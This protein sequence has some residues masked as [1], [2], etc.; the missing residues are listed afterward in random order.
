MRNRDTSDT[1]QALTRDVVRLSVADTDP[2]TLARRIRRCAEAALNAG[3]SSEQLL[4][5]LRDAWRAH[6]GEESRPPDKYDPKLTRL[7]DASLTVYFAPPADTGASRTL[8]D[9]S[10]TYRDEAPER[11]AR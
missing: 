3:L 7:I 8:I 9:R 11:E 5:T 4:V 6:A 2:R 1:V 10:S